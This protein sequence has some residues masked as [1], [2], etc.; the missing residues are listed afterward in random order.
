[1]HRPALAWTAL[2]LLS[3]GA[4]AGVAHSGLQAIVPVEDDAVRV[5][6]GHGAGKWDVHLD[7]AEEV[8]GHSCTDCY[9]AGR[10][11]LPVAGA[12]L[13]SLSPP[14]QLACH[15]VWLPAS[16]RSDRGPSPRAPPLF[17]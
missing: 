12:A 5:S 9:L 17:C 1:M 3:L 10:A 8:E 11:P 13:G 7:A 6:T 2:L 4:V 14:A 15:D 16:Q